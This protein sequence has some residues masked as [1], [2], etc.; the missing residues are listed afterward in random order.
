MSTGR[1]SSGSYEIE[2]WRV[3]LALLASAD[4]N[5]VV[6]QLGVGRSDIYRYVL[7]LMRAGGVPADRKNR[8]GFRIEAT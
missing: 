7:D 5:D 2:G 8:A 6:R 4:I 1:P 3:L